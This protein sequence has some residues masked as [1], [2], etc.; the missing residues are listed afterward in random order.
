MILMSDNNVKKKKWVTPHSSYDC[1]C[2]DDGDN[3]VYT[4]EFELPGT[5]KDK[6]ELTFVE[7]GFRLIA[8]RDDKTEY[9]SEF[10]FCCPALIDKVTADYNEGMLRIEVPLVCEDP[11]KEGKIV[12][13]N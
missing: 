1:G 11:F 7:E 12:T 13:I 6:I 4:F 8:P 2:S 10:T 5:Q 9:Y 3:A